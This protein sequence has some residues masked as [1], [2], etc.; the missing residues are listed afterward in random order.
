MGGFP[1]TA[2][3]ELDDARLIANREIEAGRW[4]VLR[5]GGAGRGLR[6][7]FSSPH[8]SIARAWFLKRHREMRQGSLL[9]VGPDAE[10]HEYVSAPM[11]RRR[12]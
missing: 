1:S 6:V 7:A 9:L 10:L 8:E 12:W 2:Y 11:V 5:N 4:C 3:E